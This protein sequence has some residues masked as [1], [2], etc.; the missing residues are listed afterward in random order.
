MWDVATPLMIAGQHVGNIFSG[1]FFF[2]GEI[3]DRESFRL[4]ARRY[5]FDEQRYLE[6]LDAVPRLSRDALEKGVAFFVKLAQ[7]LSLTGYNNL[8]L[9][10]LLSERDALTR[11]LQSSQ[12]RLR[13]ALEAA[14]MG[15]WVYTFADQVC[16]CGEH[17]QSLYGLSSSRFIHDDEGMK[18]LIHPEDLD[19]MWEALRAAVDPAGPGRY[20]TEYRTRHPDG[21]Y[22]WLSVWGLVEFEGEGKERRPVRMIGA[23]RDI[24]ASKEA[25]AALQKAQE[26]LRAH[27]QDLEHTVARR[28]A[29]LQETVAELEHFSYAIVHDMRAPLRAMQGFADIVEQECMGCHRG[30]Q[31]YFRRIRVATA[32]MDQLITDSLNYSKALRQELPLEPVDLSALLR[33]LVDTYP[34]L[35]PDKAHIDLQGPLPVVL[36]NPSALTQCFSNL[37]GNA[38]KFGKPYKI[39]NII[40]RAEEPRQCSG[41][42]MIRIWVEDDG[43]GIPETLLPRVFDMFQ[44]GSNT[45]EG[46]GIGLAIVRKVVERMGGRSGVESQEGQ[47]SRFWVELFMAS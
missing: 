3:P 45:H 9:A 10:R 26:A 5:G 36:G 7:M 37:L 33:D 44:R 4:Q 32:R 25:E 11:S 14:E 17:A 2:E 30:S 1:Q 28:T 35:Q 27:A 38:A 42:E 40:V 43:I 20:H 12:Q 22:R 6:A 23:S 47:G 29:R 15:T 46:T 16:E 18:K 39:P 21:T 24:S 13:I 8:K 41:Q 19:G 34:N 31:E